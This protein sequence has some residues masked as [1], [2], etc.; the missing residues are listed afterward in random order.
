MTIEPPC[1]LDLPASA[2]HADPCGRPS[3]SSSVA[4]T[5]IRQSPYHAW[6]RHPKLGGVAGEP[7]RETDR[8]SLI[9]ALVL[10]AGVG[11][12]VEIVPFDSYRTRAAQE[13]RDAARDGGLIPVLEREY[14]D[15][16]AV[17]GAIVAGMG[18]AGVAYTGGLAEHT[19]V[20][21]EPTA[22]GPVLCRGMM[23][24][25]HPDAGLILDLKTCRTAHPKA[26]AAHVAEY[27]Y[28]IQAA[29]YTSAVEKIRPDLAGRVDFAWVFAE[30]LPAGS[31][32]RVILTV[33]RPSGE[34]RE[35][36][37]LRWGRACE[38]WA[39]CLRDDHWP[40]YGTE[41]IRL[42]PPAWAMSEEVGR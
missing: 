17:A 33:A 18:E 21:D 40:G 20:W 19:I 4:A 5:L 11:C 35:Y 26:C 36:G 7:T 10:G 42:D 39:A 23:D 25:L 31:P 28:D 1:L 9:H 6:L 34:M 27:G 13:L 22:A 3:L 16:A 8:G 15:A 2:Y 14:A 30:E 37:R 41:E 12:G 32:R 38:A 29:A 24:L